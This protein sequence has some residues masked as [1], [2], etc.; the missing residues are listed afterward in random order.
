MPDEPTEEA[1]IILEGLGNTVSEIRR[2][3]LVLKSLA[4]RVANPSELIKLQK[5]HQSFEL[6]MFELTGTKAGEESLLNNL[7]ATASKEEVALAFE[8]NSEEEDEEQ[9][10]PVPPHIPR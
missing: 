8:E 3:Y 5:L 6:M 7:P 9:T 2:N 10:E 1:G 4:T